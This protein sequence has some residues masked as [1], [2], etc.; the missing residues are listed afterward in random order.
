MVDAVKYAMQKWT[1]YFNSR[2]IPIASTYVAKQ[3]SF[4]DSL[5]IKHPLGWIFV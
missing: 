4:P 5:F 3:I 2:K 1:A